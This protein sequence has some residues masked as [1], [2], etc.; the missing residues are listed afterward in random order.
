MADTKNPRVPEVP[1][2]PM[3]LD[4]W[5]PRAFSPEPIPEKTLASLF[6]AARW[7]PS[8]FGEQPWL[9]LYA[10]KKE[11]LELFRTLLVDGNRVWADRAPVLAFVFARRRF[12][13]NNKPNRWY[14]FDSGAAWMS[15]AL[16]ARKLGLYTHG[17]GGFHEEKVYPA[18]NVPREDYEAMAGIAIGRMGDASLL[19]QEVAAKEFPNSR[20]PLAEVAYAGKFA[21]GGKR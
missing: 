17:M 21:G 8:C 18:L 19:P 13:H 2:D 6:E 5:S 1:V 10:S 7:A 9:F 20:K 11:D 16:E 4:R 12:A 14:A 15:L 3:F